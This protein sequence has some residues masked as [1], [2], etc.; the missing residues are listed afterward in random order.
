V[1]KHKDAIK[2][3]RLKLKGLVEAKPKLR[4]EIHALKF[5]AE[6]KRRPETG[7]ERQ[8]LKQNYN[9][10]VRPEIRTVLL[11]CGILRGVP[12]KRMEAKACPDKYGYPSLL[13]ST[14]WEIHQAMG[15]NEELKA[16]WTEPRLWE[17]L[18]NDADPVALEAA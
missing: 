11:A 1:K 8:G 7:P 17:I 5:G 2:N 3:L 9:E 15:D 10:R 14:L 13:S 12:Y 16:E 18:Y 6:G 4:A